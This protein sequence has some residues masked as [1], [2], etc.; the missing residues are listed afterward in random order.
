MDNVV[1][2]SH[3]LLAHKLTYLRD[4]ST[5]PKEFRRLLEEMTQLIVYDATRNLQT[6][7]VN[8]KTPMTTMTSSVMKDEIVIIPILRAG[9][10]MEYSIQQL[11]PTAKVAHVGMFRDPVTH[12]PTIYYKKFPKQ[13]NQFEAIIVDPLLATGGSIIETISIL[14]Q[15]YVQNI[16]VVCI[17]GV[18]EGIEAIHAAF[19]DVKIYLA[20]IDPILNENKYIVPGLGDAGDRL[21]GTK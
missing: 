16:R 9:L 11:I 21:F 20:A 17:I 1:V 5:P 4:E 8:V 13:L 10:G 6:K 2:S 14:K 12:V 15:N 19:P 3:P 7:L 18:K